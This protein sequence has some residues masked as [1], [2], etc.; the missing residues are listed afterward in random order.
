M[1]V[2]QAPLALLPPGLPPAITHESQQQHPQHP[3]INN[4]MESH[5]PNL[6]PHIHPNNIQPNQTMQPGTNQTLP[7]GPNQTI[8]DSIRA[9]MG[10]PPPPPTPPNQE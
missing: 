7:P 10:L 9:N 1:M 8:T 5:N 2:P 4:I 3:P 6:P